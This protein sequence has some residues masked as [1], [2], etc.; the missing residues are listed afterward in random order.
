[1]VIKQLSA[2]T[3]RLIQIL[4]KEIQ[5]D[6]RASVLNKAHETTQQVQANDLKHQM[7]QWIF[8]ILKMKNKL[9]TGNP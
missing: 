4:L 5:V 6:L 9:C 3:K 8:K 2:Q 7:M 1:M